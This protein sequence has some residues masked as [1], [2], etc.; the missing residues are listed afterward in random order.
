MSFIV[1]DASFSSV[2]K[3]ENTTFHKIFVRACKIFKIMLVKNLLL[4]RNARE[5]KVSGAFG[6]SIFGKIRAIILFT[7]FNYSLDFNF[8]HS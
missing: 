1:P 4:L 6:P 2:L 3:L 7:C 5:Y 8:N